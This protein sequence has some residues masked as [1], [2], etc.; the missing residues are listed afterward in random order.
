MNKIMSKNLMILKILTYVPE[1][2]KD[3]ERIRMEMDIKKDGFK[4]EVDEIIGWASKRNIN[5]YEE[6]FVGDEE[7]GQTPYSVISYK[8]DDEIRKN[9]PSNIFEKK[10]HDIGVK[11]KLPF[12]FYAFPDSGLPRYVLTGE[13]ISPRQNFFVDFKELKDKSI[14]VSLIAYTPLSK[15]EFVDVIN[16]M[17][18]HTSLL[19]NFFDGIE[20]L[21][22]KR[23]HNKILRDLETFN[24]QISKPGK[25]KKIKKYEQQSYL[26]YIM[27]SKDVSIRVKQRTERKCNDS[28][29]VDYDKPTSKEIGKKHKVSGDAVR[30]SKKRLNSFA[31]EIF[32]YGLEP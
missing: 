5:S 6:S 21:S 17:G 24:D 28:I 9:F 14:L 20:K 2:E 11:Y 12:N 32:G 15:K 1:F 22:K 25:P 13:I 7:E 29:I 27:K 3:V 19:S 10:I 26:D 4:W 18:E 30:Q 23:Y 8:N 31:K 16:E